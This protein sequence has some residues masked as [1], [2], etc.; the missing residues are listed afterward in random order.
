MM[1]EA[2]GLGLLAAAIL[3]MGVL[4]QLAVVV[5]KRRKFVLAVDALPGPKPHPVY[6]NVPDLMVPPNSE[7]QD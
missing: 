3:V 7:C 6:G 2:S 5:F 4:Y 1:M